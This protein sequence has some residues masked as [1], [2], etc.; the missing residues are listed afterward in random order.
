MEKEDIVS[1][2]RND[3][4]KVL[5]YIKAV[6]YAIGVTQPSGLVYFFF[7]GQAGVSDSFFQNI[8]QDTIDTILNEVF[9]SLRRY[10]EYNFVV[11]TG[12]PWMRQ[13]F[14]YV[15]INHSD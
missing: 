9:G 4:Q 15:S 5:N 1:E 3:W 6:T 12:F 8:A 10:A 11:F 14:G 2:K 13:F 7:I